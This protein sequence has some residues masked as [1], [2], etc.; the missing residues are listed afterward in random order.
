M[1]ILG[2]ESN[3]NGI[4]GYVKTTEGASLPFAGI[5]IQG[6]SQGT[7]A[8]EEGYYEFSLVP[9]KYKIVFQYLGFRTHIEEVTIASDILQINIV[10]Q[11]Q[12]LNLSEAVIGNQKEDLAISIMKKAIAKAK[13]HQLQVRSYKAS[14]YSRASAIAT[15]IPFLLQKR[16]KKE[17]IEKGKAFLNESVAEISYTRPNTYHQKIISTRNSLDNSLPTPNEFIMASLYSPQVAGAITPLSPRAFSFYDFKYEGYFEDQGQ[18]INKI[19]VIPKAYG[20]GVFRGTIY[21]LEET[22][23]IHSYDLETT[24]SGLAI[25]AKQIFSPVKNV[26]LPVNQQFKLNGGYLGFAGQ[27]KYLVSVNYK[28]LDVDPNLTEKVI[29]NDRLSKT[30]NGKTNKEEGLADLIKKQKQFSTK[31]FNKLSKEY[32]EE[33]IALDP[34]VSKRMI[35]S[36]SIEI[37]TMANKRETAY[38]QALRPIPLTPL[39]VKSYTIQDSIKMVKEVSHINKR[40]D[41]TTIKLKHF[42]L[43]N[44]Y[45]LGNK[46]YLDNPVFSLN[47]NTVE[48]TA[49]NML[50]QL[51][52]KWGKGSFVMVSPYLRYALGRHR[53]NG[54]MLI[55]AG[56]QKWDIS[57]VGGELAS[58]YNQN[59]PAQPFPNSVASRFFDRNLMKLYQNQFVK[60]EL[61]VRNVWDILNIRTSLEIQ[62]RTELFN[63]ENASSLI[64]FK[65]Y[66]YT[67]NRPKN[68]EL[69]NTGFQSHRA[70]IFELGLTVSPWRRYIIRNGRKRYVQNP[71]AD[72][73]VNYKQGVGPLGDVDFSN[74]QLGITQELKLGPRSIFNYSV[75]TG[76]FINSKKTYFMDYK[77]FMGNE[78]FLQIGDPLNNFRMLPYYQYSTKAWFVQAHAFWVFQRLLLTNFEK[79]RTTGVKET[80]QFHYLK[81]PGIKNYSE[82]GY[83][84]DEVLR[85]FRLEVIGQFHDYK[86]Q[87]L[88]FRIGTSIQIGKGRR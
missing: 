40:P 22:W 25:S 42:V 11:I 5:T 85:I 27:F 12:A 14:V 73:I 53:M 9:G 33:Q 45:A 2:F 19:K 74:L 23:A 44:T 64:L 18:F 69:D 63:L 88:G 8:N 66:S 32:A 59:N 46:L 82:I 15:K 57:L 79:V 84:F 86:I 65:N 29:I 60:T 70:A 31:E 49:I 68:N 87:S 1:L 3:A 78:F 16:L 43:G 17:G 41:S 75:S 28:I 52:K 83:G 30:E 71:G 20:E 51:E 38:W 35:R 50:T 67:P 4:K 26:W 81:T 54:T 10:L 37:D 47:F 61:L 24:K 7:M 80:I 55:R 72:F 58:Q 34:K 13:F 62:Q 76:G 36:D 77:H 6:T 39:E 56:N 21:I 48:G